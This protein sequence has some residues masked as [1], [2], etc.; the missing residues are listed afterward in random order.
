MLGYDD[1]KKIA[2]LASGPPPEK[3][4]PISQP[5]QPELNID[6]EVRLALERTLR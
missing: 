3:E 4:Q 2:Q 6:E 1:A 5:P